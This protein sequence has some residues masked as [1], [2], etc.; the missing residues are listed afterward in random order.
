MLR[1]S[2]RELL[3]FVALCALA[4]VSLKYA[5]ETWL[6]VVLGLALLAFLSAI[7]SAAV[8]RGP[9]QAAGLAFCL[10]LIVYG[11]VVLKIPQW[12]GN[13][14][15]AT[16]EFSL[17]NGRLPT[18]L[19]L[20]PVYTAMSRERWIDTSTQKAIPNFDPDNPSIPIAN[21]S[22]G[23]MPFPGPAAM[24]Q[25]LPSQEMFAPIGHLWWA[26]LL[27][28]A[29]GRYGQFIYKRRVRELQAESRR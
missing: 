11:W 6:A 27:G 26:L 18:T 21:F 22:N 10:V 16:A 12:P 13:L 24:S 15:S 5:S 7:I 28:Y 19:V 17:W 4:L 1:I 8:D 14:Q 25:I 23:A 3:A 9:R 20:R 2:L 29:G